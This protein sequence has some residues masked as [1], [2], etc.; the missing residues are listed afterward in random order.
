[1]LYLSSKSRNTKQQEIH[2][3]LNDQILS[4]V[5]SIIEESNA[6][7]LWLGLR[8]Q[9]HKISQSTFNNRLR[10]LVNDGFVEKRS[11]GYNK[12]Y[13][14]ATGNIDNRHHN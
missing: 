5:K 3:Q 6:E 4:Y 9:G 12:Y 10:E 11:I 2:D 7:T 1:M 13:Y 14:L 8:S